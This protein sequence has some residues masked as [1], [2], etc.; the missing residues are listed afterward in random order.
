[1]AEMAGMNTL[2]QDLRSALRQARRTPGMTAAVVLSLALGIGACTAM[3]CLVWALVLRPLPFTDPGALMSVVSASPDLPA[4][5]DPNWWKPLSIL[6]YQDL[7]TQS[8]PLVEME[9]YFDNYGLTLTGG[10]P[11][12]V[13]GALV[14]AGLLPLLGAK[15]L[16]G[17]HIRR[18]EDRW[19]SES[20]VLLGYGLWQRRFAGDPQII[21]RLIAANS[22]HYRVAGVMP[23]GFDFPNGNEAWVALGPETPPAQGRSV[24]RLQAVARRRPGVT[25]DA[26]R[27]AL[28]SLGQRL[29]TLDPADAGWRIEILPLRRVL[30]GSTLQRTALAILVA[31]IA[32]LL[33][34]CANVS[35]LLL[36]QGVKRRREI[37]VRAALGAGPRRIVRQILTESLVLAAAGGALGIPLGVAGLRL[38]RG[39]LP[40]LPYG[41]HL[42]A[43]L[44]ALAAA[45]GISLGAGLLFGTAPAL[46]ACRPDLGAAFRHAEPAGRGAGRLH[47]GLIVSE[48]ALSA[49]LLIAAAL[50]IRTLSALR[51]QGAAPP[52]E[53]LYTAWITFSDRRY[54]DWEARARG[55][56]TI[57]ERLAR[58]PGIESA[59]GTNFVPLAIINGLEGQIETESAGAARQTALC[60]TLTAGFFTTWGLRLVAGRD[61]TPDEASTQSSAAVINETLARRLWPDGRAVGRRFRVLG[62]PVPV[63]WLTVVGV[64]G[65]FKIGSLRDEVQGQVFVSSAYNAFRPAAL[66]VRTRLP[67]AAALAE[68]RRAVHGVDPGL[69]LFLSATMDQVSADHLRSERLSSAG[70]AL[71][72]SVALFFAAIGT[73]GVLAVAVARRRREI[74]VRLALGAPRGRLFRRLVGRGLALTVL[75]LALG[76]LTG[77]AVSRALAGQLFGVSATD[78]FS[79]GGVSILLLDVAFAACYLPA[80]RA[81]DID[82]AEALRQ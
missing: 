65:D 73:Y 70:L 9:A 68:V 50:S 81:L 19:E 1:M 58:R 25:A 20:V 10:E 40:P 24:R 16:L 75:G 67:P 4:G 77:L 23:P 56:R 71:F 31:V 39:A 17:R 12:R 28:E 55:L 60:S 66:V 48:V 32:V 61:L 36:A 51:S 34:A 35:S 62:P 30:L 22:S 7:R 82:P 41:L 46:H 5:S 72:G 37:A 47:A 15:P 57:A 78:P 69:P 18:D 11:E 27:A 80:R 2:Q 21:G 79:F 38:L 43:D 74:A 45:F 53:P 33:I 13:K 54:D 63:G 26:A 8:R 52:P 29:A 64:A 59:A 49:V 44:P 6:D 14:S 76:L 3:L 42:T